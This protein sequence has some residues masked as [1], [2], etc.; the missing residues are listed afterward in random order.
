MTDGIISAINRDVNSDGNTMT[1]LQTTAALNSGNSGG[2]AEYLR[3]GGGHY[4]HEDDSYPTPLRASASP[5]LGHRQKPWWMNSLSGGIWRVGPPWASPARPSGGDGSGP[6]TGPGVYVSTV[7]PNS[8]AQKGGM[9]PGTSLPS[10]TAGGLLR[11]G[12]QRRQSGLQ[13]RGH[14]H[15]PGFPRGG[16]SDL[17]SL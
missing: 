15:L 6:R 11:G 9:F 8:G 7:D 3:P 4:Q 12:Y 17:R 10:A 2:P 16:I 14:P 5:F 13:G 1:L